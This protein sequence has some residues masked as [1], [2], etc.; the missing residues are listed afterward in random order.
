MNF[1]EFVDGKAQQPLPPAL[2]DHE[3]QIHEFETYCRNLMLKILELFAIGLKVSVL[4]LQH[5]Q[6]SRSMIAD[7]TTDIS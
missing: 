1:G 7:G 4:T 2:V 6:L 5:L 3:P